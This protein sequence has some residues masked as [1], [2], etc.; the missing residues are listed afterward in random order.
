MVVGLVSLARWLRPYDLATEKAAARAAGVP[1]TPAE[2]GITRPPAAQDAY[3]LWAALG[4]ALKGIPGSGT[5]KNEIDKY[6]GPDG[7]LKPAGRAAA[8]QL[9]ASH[10]A[11]LPRIREAAARPEAYWPITYSALTWSF[12]TGATMRSA[13][14]IL[15]REAQWLTANDRYR[16]AAAMADSSFG[17]SRHA[18]AAP[19]A[20]NYL[21]SV[22]VDAIALHDLEN[23]LRNA[24]PDAGAAT[25][26]RETIESN[27]PGY[28]IVRALRGE[29]VFSLNALDT[30]VALGSPLAMAGP[31]SPGGLPP[32]LCG[33]RPPAGW[34]RSMYIEPSQA[35]YLHDMTAML[36]AARKPTRAA[37][38]P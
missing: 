20:I 5:L 2:V 3:P 16:D 12:E 8:R 34:W 18:G 25:A 33:L 1:T 32:A 9:S 30:A 11:I 17:V 36:E 7:L 27:P 37:S 38:P 13:A 10:A 14:Q 6:T 24:G 21:V 23:I 15:S 29:A 35:A 28:D 19:T 22:A 26:V 31:G 4:P